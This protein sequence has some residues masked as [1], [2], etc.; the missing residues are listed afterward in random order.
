MR[1]TLVWVMV[2]GVLIAGCGGGSD[3]SDSSNS[4]ASGGADSSS[5]Q[6]AGDAQYIDPFQNDSCLSAREIRQKIHRIASQAQNPE[7]QKKAIQ[8]VRDRAC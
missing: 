8:A 5:K 3:S 6:S 7:H 1:K 2:A 4:G